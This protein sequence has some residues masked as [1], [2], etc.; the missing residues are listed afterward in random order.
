MEKQRNKVILIVLAAAMTMAACSADSDEPAG[1]RPQGTVA[2]SPQ[3]G[4]LPM[5]AALGIGAPAGQQSVDVATRGNALGTYN[6]G[7]LAPADAVGLFLLKAGAKAKTDD[8]FEQWNKE[9]AMDAAISTTSIGAAVNSGMYYPELASQHCDLYAYYPRVDNAGTDLTAPTIT[10]TPRSDQTADGDYHAS[11]VLWGCAGDG[12]YVKAS[13]ASGG[14]YQK[15]VEAGNAA[16]VSTQRYLALRSAANGRSGAYLVNSGEP[17]AYVPLLHRCAKIYVRVKASGMNLNRLQNAIVRVR[18][19]YASG[20]LNLSTGALTTTGTAGDNAIVLTNRL[21]LSGINSGG[22]IVT[23]FDTS[24]SPYVQGAMQSDGTTAAT[25]EANAASYTCSA[26]VIPQLTST[27]YNFIEVTPYANT[28]AH[29]EGATSTNPPLA[30]YGYKPASAITLESGKQYTFNITVT[31]TGIA[32]V[33]M[34]VEHWSENNGI[35]GRAIIQ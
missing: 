6:S 18:L 15:L 24:T 23:S 2:D 14:A 8:S 33:T 31:A 28:K 29:T 20:Q 25:T 11:D 30:T 17:Y 35:N 26:V 7:A 32:A 34:A 19:P 4:R 3:Q 5:T 1:S 21:G 16:E 22:G 12:Q 13:V 10:Y 27:S 9:A